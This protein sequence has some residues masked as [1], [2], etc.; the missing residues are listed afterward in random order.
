MVRAWRRGT[1]DLH[2]S[3]ARDACRPDV[4]AGA[5]SVA[6]ASCVDANVVQ[7]G[8]DHGE[9]APRWLASSGFQPGWSADTGTALTVGM[10]GEPDAGDAPG[11]RGTGT[12][13]VA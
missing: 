10:A 7:D 12:G 5:A 2:H 6:A 13:F 3:A 8:V 11:L 4:L 9:R 1:A